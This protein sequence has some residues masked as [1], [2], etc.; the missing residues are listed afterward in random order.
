MLALLLGAVAIVGTAGISARAADDEEIELLDT[1]IFKG[2]MKALGVT[3]DTEIEYRERP[4]LVLPN[5][6][7]LPSPEA[8]N[9]AAKTAN[10]PVDADVTSAKKRKA[11]RKFSN[12]DPDDAGRPLAPNQDNRPGT[13]SPG[14]RPNGTTKTTED[15]ERPM[16]PFELGSNGLL[17]KWWSPSEEYST[18][19]T[20]PTRQSLI[21]PPAGYRTPSP[22]QP[23]GVG[24]KTWQGENQTAATRSDVV[25]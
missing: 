13:G 10:W 20:E 17:T 12:P 4:Q 21:D 1:K 18:F 6:K 19:T 15:A 5:G 9:R 8:G 14:N 3:R 24:Q 11:E 7:D 22:S 16:S 2:V 25:K 23:Y